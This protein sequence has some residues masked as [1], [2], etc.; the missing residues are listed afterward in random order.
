MQ[1]DGTSSNVREDKEGLMCLYPSKRCDNRRVMKANGQLHNF[2]Q[3]HRDKANYNQ[4][5]LEFKRKGLQ[6]QNQST[7]E[8]AN[9]PIQGG[10]RPIL[11]K[12]ATN[13]GAS[14][15]GSDFELDKEH[16]RL[17]EDVASANL[18]SSLGKD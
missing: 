8:H 11:P 4:R 13:G 9:I 17:I 12:P 3:F 14:E 7:N 16:L 15:C 10:G 18:D 2:C 6:S 5:Q 1:H